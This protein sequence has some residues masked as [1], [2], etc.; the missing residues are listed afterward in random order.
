MQ[1]RMSIPNIF[2]SYFESAEQT[3]TSVG[4]LTLA[5]GLGVEPKLI[6]ALLVCKTAEFGYSINDRVVIDP[7]YANPATDRGHS[8]VV[9]NINL[10]IR[11][12][13]NGYTLIHK[14]GG[15][16]ANI[17]SANWKVIFRAWA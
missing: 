5:H 13:T 9:D 10:N 14:T 8:V 15:A 16:A 17:T 4:S 3:I 1:S 6:Q 12:S 11:F 7:S 2:T